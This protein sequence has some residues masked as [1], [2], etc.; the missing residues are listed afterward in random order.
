MDKGRSNL[1]PEAKDSVGLL[2][3]PEPQMVSW[4]ALSRSQDKNREYVLVNKSFIPSFFTALKADIRSWDHLTF[5]AT[6]G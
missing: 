3:D 1:P 4:M 5:Q 2:D 6:A